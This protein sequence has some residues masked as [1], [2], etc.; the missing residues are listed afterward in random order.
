M[1]HP[2]R[3]GRATRRALIGVTACLL[4]I[5][6]LPRPAAAALPTLAGQPELAESRAP[7]PA[8]ARP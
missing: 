5:A 1:R 6:A 7:R 3:A 4:G 8:P 2:Q